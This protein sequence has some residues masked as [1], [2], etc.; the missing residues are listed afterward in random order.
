MGVPG[1]E[2]AD[3][4][5]LAR[6]EELGLLC[7]HVL[8]G[9]ESGAPAAVVFG[10]PGVGKSRMLREVAD[11]ARRQDIPVLLTI[12]TKATRATPYG[13]LAPVVSG[14]A[15]AHDSLTAWYSAVVE[16]IHPAGSAVPLLVVDDAHQLDAG[17]AALLLH[18]ALSGAAR[19]LLG[20]RRGEVTPDPVTTLWK[21]EIAI[22]VDLQPFSSAEIGRLIEAGLGG[23]VSA[24]TRAALARQSQGNALFARELVRAAVAAGSLSCADG[25]WRWDGSVVLAPRLVD[26][27][28][29]R[30]GHLAADDR[31]SLALL[32]L[33]EPLRS[34]VAEDLLGTEPLARLEGTGLARLDDAGDWRLDH[35]LYG[36]VVLAGLR[37]GERRRLV[38]QLVDALADRPSTAPLDVVR[39]ARWRLEVGAEPDPG[40]L[41]EAAVLA[42]A[43][44]DTAL[45]EQLARAAVERGGPPRASVALAN[46]C[47]S[48]NRFAEAEGALADAE[49]RILAHHDIELH[50]RYVD[51]RHQALYMG[52]R[53]RDETL[54]MLDRFVAAHDAAPAEHRAVAQHL[55]ASYR[56]EVL[57]DE[58]RLADVLE[59]VDPILNDASVTP[60]VALHAAEIVGEVLARQGRTTTSRGTHRRLRELAASGGPDARR[61]AATSILQE[62]MCLTLEGWADRAITVVEP[63]SAAMAQ[64]PDPHVRALVALVVGGTQLPRGRFVAARRA[65]LDAVAGFAVRDSGHAGAW[66]STMLARAH[67]VLG[68]LDAARL[69]LDRADHLQRGRLS[70][71]MLADHLLAHAELTAAAGDSTGASRSLLDGADSLGELPVDRAKVLHSAAC[72]G[73]PLRRVRDELAPLTAVESPFPTLLLEHVE[74]LLSRDPDRLSAV[75]RTFAAQGLTPLAA[76]AASDAAAAHRDKGHN[77]LARQELTREGLLLARCDGAHLPSVAP[78]AELPQL[79]RRES[80]VAGLAARGLSN[81]DIANQL[82]LSVRTVESHLY[83]VFAKLGVA[84]R[85][86]LAELLGGTSVVDH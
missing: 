16:A 36:D 19:L 33:G 21:D 63:I 7:G 78:G 39:I 84:H 68:E 48:R 42:N 59:L 75:S 8:A 2:L 5:F 54:A 44:F 14:S 40:L 64:E 70:S 28:G 76:R 13:A 55:A 65:L 43:S 49:E 85:R 31:A 62:C 73:A 23:E 56:A 30:I 52:L 10:Q 86:E 4:P 58:G 46:A 15:A 60:L 27:V 79:S 57:L 37:R 41:T 69:A 82:T 51:R 6:T 34:E 67:I 12:A 3:W 35:P 47:N 20:V 81:A 25:V 77:T 17:S 66:A 72:L 1:V 45:G 32:A 50:Q 11:V 9:G 29:E 38:R 71:R 24:S 80:E 53:R 61:A 22:R 83:Q 18:L 26:A 74:G